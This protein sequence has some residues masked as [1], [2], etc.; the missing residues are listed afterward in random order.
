M[1]VLSVVCFIFE[2]CSFWSVSNRHAQ[3]LDRLKRTHT[4]FLNHISEIVSSA[5]PDPKVCEI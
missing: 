3:P 1:L 2:V 4:L 5:G